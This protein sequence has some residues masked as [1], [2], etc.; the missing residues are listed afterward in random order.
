MISRVGLD[1]VE[2]GL[3]LDPALDADEVGMSWDLAEELGFAEETARD[4]GVVRP[5]WRVLEGVLGCGKL[6]SRS[7]HAWEAVRT[8]LPSA[9]DTL[10]TV[11]NLPLP[12]TPPGPSRNVYSAMPQSRSSS[13]DLTA[14][15]G[16]I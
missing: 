1:Q 9:S 11:E 3:G 16:K 15:T 10:Y 13:A 8:S 7:S 5:K 14:R 12:S 4:E 2:V 6:Q